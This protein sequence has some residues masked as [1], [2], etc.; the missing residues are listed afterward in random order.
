MKKI[1]ASRYKSLLTSCV[2]AAPRLCVKKL[3]N[4]LTQRRGDAKTQ[5][6]IGLIILIFLAGCAVGP[7]YKQPENNITDT[8]ASET[9]LSNETPLVEWWKVFNDELLSKY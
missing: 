8:W 6:R 2:F 4:F 7:N 9:T 1:I 3:V 5:S